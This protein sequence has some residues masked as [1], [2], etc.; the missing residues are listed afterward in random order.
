MSEHRIE[1]DMEDFNFINTIMEIV[2]GIGGPLLVA[3][4]TNRKATE[5]SKFYSYITLGEEN[6]VKKTKRKSNILMIIFLALYLAV[7]LNGTLY[8]LPINENVLKNARMIGLLILSLITIGQSVC[9]FILAFSDIEYLDEKMRKQKRDISDMDEW[10]NWAITIICVAGFV[11]ILLCKKNSDAVSLIAYS[12]V[13]ITVG[14]EAVY[15]SFISL[16]VKV[17]RW[18]YV[19]EIIIR[20]KTT[21]KVYKNIFNYRKSTG[22]YEFVCE[23]ENVLKRI[24]VP[25][26]EVESIEKKIDAGKTYLDTMRNKEVNSVKK[27]NKKK[28]FWCD[29]ASQ[30]KA[31]VV[32]GVSAV[33]YCLACVFLKSSPTLNVSEKMYPWGEFF[34]NVAISVIAAVIFFIVQVYMPNRKREQT[35]KKYAKRYIKEVLLSECNILKI[36]TEAIRKGEHSEAEMKEAINSSCVKIKKALNESLNNYLQVLSEELIEAMNSVLFDD[37]LYMISIRANGNLVNESLEKILRD[38]INYKFL[39]DRVDKIKLE[40]EKL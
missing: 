9:N 21:Q 34:F 31:I 7:G 20:T 30:N 39:W 27:K 24:S 16:Y 36:R 11:L 8:S 23:E 14:M 25:V 15:N 38:Q 18:Y 13:L 2:I 29:F 26:E 22:V 35:L 4:A 1:D 32:T 28:G 10:I 37:M 5:E 19:G 17:R 6:F 40:I 33:I 12:T 3:Y